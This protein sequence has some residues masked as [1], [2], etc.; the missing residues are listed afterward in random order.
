MA[1]VLTKE[2]LSDSLKNISPFGKVTV[3]YDARPDMDKELKY[4]KTGMTFGRLIEA[5]NGLIYLS[6][7][8]PMISIEDIMQLNKYDEQLN[9]TTIENNRVT[10]VEENNDPVNRLLLYY[11][12]SNN[13][14]PITQQPGFGYKVAIN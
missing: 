7:K 12:L 10:K 13:Q 5:K 4:S 11:L 8:D 3:Y 9:G 1:E 14:Q 2:E 6:Y